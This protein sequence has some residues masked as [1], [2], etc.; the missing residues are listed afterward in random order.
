[1]QQVIKD[2]LRQPEHVAVELRGCPV[3]EV[4]EPEVF[5][6]EFKIEEVPQVIQRQEIFSSKVVL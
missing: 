3:I 6:I 2:E 5:L 1:M 4:L